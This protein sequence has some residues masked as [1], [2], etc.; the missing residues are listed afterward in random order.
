MADVKKVIE[1]IKKIG[2]DIEDN[3]D[4]LTELD[5]RRGKNYPSVKNQVSITST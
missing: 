2:A 3:K 5:K 1:I 4:F